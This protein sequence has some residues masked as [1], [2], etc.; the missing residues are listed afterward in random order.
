MKALLTASLLMLAGPAFALS[1]GEG[2]ANPPAAVT[3]ASYASW[4]GAINS[5]ES[6]F[7][8]HLFNWQDEQLRTAL[9]APVNSDPDKLH[10]A[11]ERPMRETIALEASGDIEEGNTIGFEAY[12][13][14]PA[15]IGTVLEA[16]LFTWG[17]PVG[18]AEGET[19]PFD[20]VFSRKHDTIRA[21]WGAGNYYS[22]SDTSGG[23]IVK[24]LHDDYTLLV[25]GSDAEGYTL[26]A[27]FFAARESSPTTS[28]ISIVMLKPLPGGRTEF[29]QSVRQ[30]G[31]SYKIFGIDYGRR[32][33]GFNAAK[34]R[35]GQKQF[36][37][38]VNELKT[39]GKIRENKPSF[40]D[41]ENF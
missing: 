4:L 3:R 33:F 24:N 18:R 23:G 29:R 15:P 32:N 19:W 1:A 35:E 27:G 11:V 10:V 9:P 39:T 16:K 21:K 14:I 6:A 20:S 38:S 7:H 12:A 34:V 41:L 28:H 30:Q 22:T 31:Q 36:F 2:R 17:K 37:A 5:A 40:F 8:D 13:I 26:Y 25:R